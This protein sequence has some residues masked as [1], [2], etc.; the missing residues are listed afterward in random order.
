MAEALG[1][2]L[3]SL[4]GLIRHCFHPVP[5]LIVSMKIVNSFHTLYVCMM[6]I[7]LHVYVVYAVYEFVIL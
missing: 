6:L 4:Y 5:A 7:L 2:S 3:L 1:C